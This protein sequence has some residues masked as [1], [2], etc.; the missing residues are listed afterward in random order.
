MADAAF[1]RVVWGPKMTRKAMKDN[2]SPTRRRRVVIGYCANGCVFLI[3]NTAYWLL[4]EQ[5][6]DLVFLTPI[7]PLLFGVLC[8]VIWPLYIGVSEPIE[9]K[10]LVAGVVVVS[11]LITLAVSMTI[12]LRRN[13]GRRSL[14]IAHGCLLIYYLLCYASGK[15]II[16]LEEAMAC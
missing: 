13:G 5:R 3:L 2:R 10:P 11:L 6:L 7:A 1:V 15:L 14:L 16:G 9:I 8:V 4:V 12:T